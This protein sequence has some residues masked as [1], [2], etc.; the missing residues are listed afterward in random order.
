M[1]WGQEEGIKYAAH[2]EKKR[3]FIV[4]GAKTE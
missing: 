1:E 4:K 3:P 2:I